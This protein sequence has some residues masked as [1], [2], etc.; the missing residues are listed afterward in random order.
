MTELPEWWWLRSHAIT[1]LP[2]FSTH[3]AWT[4]VAGLRRFL[5]DAS[6][7]DYIRPRCFVS[8]QNIKKPPIVL[9]HFSL[10]HDLI[11]D[12]SEC[13]INVYLRRL[14]HRHIRFIQ[15]SRDDM[16]C[17]FGRL[18]GFTHYAPSYRNEEYYYLRDIWALPTFIEKEAFHDVAT[19]S[20]MVKSFPA[21]SASEWH[22]LYRHIMSNY[23]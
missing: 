1:S 5:S 23:A 20:K 18:L 7:S 4:R 22:C 3:G 6:F 2:P 21:A 8:T 10:F 13:C 14:F 19:G 12:D 9:P 15:M 16:R 11:H 17:A